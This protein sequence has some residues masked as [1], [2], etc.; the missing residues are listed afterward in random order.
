MAS[1]AC[2]DASSVAP[3]GT[4]ADDLAGSAAEAPR[5]RALRGVVELDPSLGVEAADYGCIFVMGWRGERSAAS[6][7]M[8]AKLPTTPMPVPFELDARA[9]MGAG[10]IGGQWTLVARLDGDADAPAQAGDIEG[11]TASL[12]SADDDE[13]RIRLSRRLGPGDE[14]ALT[15]GL[16]GHGA[17][18][19]APVSGVGSGLPGGHPPIDSMPA[20]HPPIDDVDQT[21]SATDAGGP[22]IRGILS[23]ADDFADLNGTA[24][25][26]VIVRNSAEGQGMPTAVLKIDR[27]EFPLEID[28]GTEHIPLQVDNKAAMLG[29]ELYITAR[30]DMDG[31]FMG[32]V[33]D[34]E[35]AAPV[36]ASTDKP[37]EG[38]LDTRRSE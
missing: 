22:R 23:L 35:L 25:L 2:D 20:G 33:G 4:A 21:A 19:Q 36:P 29:G 8:I 7:Q 13:I 10:T 24:S 5:S 9:L 32:A 27:P 37:F 16:T 3:M 34:I 28:I 30:L 12:V 15:F 17:D 6:P 26:F 38:T 11:V 14:R 31:G 1:P 18:S